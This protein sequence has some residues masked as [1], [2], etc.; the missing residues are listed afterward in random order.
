MRHATRIIADLPTEYRAAAT[1]RVL[2]ALATTGARERRM[3]M[4]SEALE[5]AMKPWPGVNTRSPRGRI[6]DTELRVVTLISI[7]RSLAEAGL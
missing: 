2:L 3:A 6:E 4:V 1:R 5:L 7:G